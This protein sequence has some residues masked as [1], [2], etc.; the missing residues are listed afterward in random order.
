MGAKLF[1]GNFPYDTT[2]TMLETVFSPFG[3]VSELRI[4]R[5]QPS[6]R[7]RGYGFVTYDNVYAAERALQE[8]HG[9]DFG[10]RPLRVDHSHSTQGGSHMKKSQPKHDEALQEA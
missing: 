1:I 10:G 2:E 7:S 6:G 8:L 5:E 3:E 4:V 9:K